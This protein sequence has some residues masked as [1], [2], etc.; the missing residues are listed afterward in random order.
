MYLK[1]NYDENILEHYVRTIYSFILCIIHLGNSA[2]IAFC[3]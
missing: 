3:I 2:P 1:F